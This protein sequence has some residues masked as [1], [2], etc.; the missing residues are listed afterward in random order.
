MV[1]DGPGTESY[2]SLSDLRS[3]SL[4]LF[5]SGKSNRDLT[6]DRPE[7]RTDTLGKKQRCSQTTE[8]CIYD[9]FL[10]RFLSVCCSSSPSALLFYDKRVKL[11]NG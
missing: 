2:L 9:F 11:V 8:I 1:Q 6:K 10:N 4:S 3:L 7:K 5:S